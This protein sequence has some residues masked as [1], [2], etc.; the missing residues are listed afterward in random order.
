MS[1]N[2][3]FDA[4]L[5]GQPDTA[6][7]L[8]APGA[9]EMTYGTL[10]AQI[11]GTMGALGEAGLGPGD[12][13][14][15]Q[16]SK[17]PEGLVLYLA[18]VAA[19]VIYVPLNPA[20][21]APE[22][23][24]F[25]QDADPGLLVLDQG[26]AAAAPVAQARGIAVAQL[27]ELIRT[28]PP[29]P[30]V[31]RGPNDIAAILY[32]SGTTGRS[33]GAMMSHANLLS[34]A[35]TLRDIWHFTAADRLLHALPIFHTHGLFVATNVV[36]AAGASMLF[37]PR[38]DVDAVVNAMPQ[39][40]TLMGVPTFYTRLLEDDRINAESLG[41]MRLMISGSAPLLAETHRGF[42]EK[43]GQVILERYGM[44]ETNMITSNP[45]EGDRRPGTVG[46]PLPGVEI[47][48]SGPDAQGIGGVELRGPNVTAGYWR[49]PD[50]TAE[51]FT[52]D[53]WF[54]TGDLGF[55][56]ADGYL[57]IVGREKDLVISGG[58][59]IYPKEVELVIDALPG[60]LESAVYG[61]PDPDLGEVVAA[62]VVLEAG[63]QTDEASILQALSGQLARFKCPRRVVVLDALPRNAMGKVQKATLRAQATS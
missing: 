21:T 17:S 51:S 41:H 16:L 18:C 63:A 11:W 56:D 24:Y 25:L 33:K 44:T 12:R 9:A 34:N 60:I 15:C 50:K 54:I 40:T 32:T 10:R 62:A 53:G 29:V 23:D 49:N 42:A 46:L 22:L 61:V 2:L 36:L 14:L 1:T 35:G 30:P 52:A 13:L 5:T 43:T 37:L 3:M 27:S 8:T 19:G 4:L 26:S 57:T 38:F 48:V 39:A 7:F 28:A 6:L 58:Y 31:P 59:N 45:Y 20:Y 55:I 47:R